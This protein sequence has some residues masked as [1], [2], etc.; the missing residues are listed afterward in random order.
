MLQ[1]T[2]DCVWPVDKTTREVI[3]VTDRLA[4]MGWTDYLERQ[5]LKMEA[6]FIEYRAETGSWVFK[7]PGF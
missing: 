4:A 1:I 3:K 6:S 5:C 7:V 2:L